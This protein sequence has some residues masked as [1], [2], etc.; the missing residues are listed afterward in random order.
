MLTLRRGLSL[1]CIGCLA[2][3]LCRRLQFHAIFFCPM[4]TPFGTGGQSNIMKTLF[5]LFFLLI[6][7]Q[8][9]HSQNVSEHRF[10][11]YYLQHR[12]EITGMPYSFEIMDLDDGIYYL[13]VIVSPSSFF[14]TTAKYKSQLTSSGIVT[15]EYE[16]GGTL[17]TALMKT[18]IYSRVKLS[19]LAKG[20]GYD[21]SIN[22]RIEDFKVQIRYWYDVE[23]PPFKDNIYFYPIKNK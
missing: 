7:I 13:K 5:T 22:D 6:T 23:N 18:R 20:I 8:T 4:S 19:D 14:Q 15:Y 3:P 16:G 11:S 12:G 21:K 9:I 1:L 10:D 17:N 2:V